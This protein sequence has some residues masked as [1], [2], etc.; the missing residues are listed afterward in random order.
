MD[1]LTPKAISRGRIGIALQL[2]GA[3]TTTVPNGVCGVPK[4]LTRQ[5]AGEFVDDDIASFL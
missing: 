5:C 2:S 1:N 3:E 4:S